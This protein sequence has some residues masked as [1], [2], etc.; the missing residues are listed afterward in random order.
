LS[1]TYARRSLLEKSRFDFVRSP[2]LLASANAS[3]SARTNYLIQLLKSGPA[4][5]RAGQGV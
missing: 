2:V 5:S 3:A 1:P 4:P